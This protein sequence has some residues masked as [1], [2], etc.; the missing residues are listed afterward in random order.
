MERLLQFLPAS[1]VAIAVVSALA[2]AQPNSGGRTLLQ[3]GNQSVSAP[4]QSP[5]SNTQIHDLLMRVGSNQHRDD[6]TLDS[7]ERVEHVVEREDGPDSP[8]TNDK[9]YRVVPTG[10]GNLRLLIRENGKPVSPDVYQRQLRDWERALEIAIHPDDPREVAVAAKQQ[11]RLK[12]RAKLIDSVA[13]AFV[14]SWQGREVRDGR[15]LEKLRFEPNPNYQPHGDSTDWL[16]HARATVWIDAQSAQIARV[17]ADIIRDISIG[18]GILGKVYHGT[19]FVM[20]Q[21]Q[22]AS[23]IWEP[24]HYEYDISGRKFLFSFELHEVT[25]L[26]RYQFI[27]APDKALVVARNNL[28]RCCSFP[29]DP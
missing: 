27:G 4:D 8:V 17:E 23:D 28:A 26:S 22:A 2:L 1:L 19:H 29:A 14:V 13:G 12:D 21:A 15:V 9:T 10:S 18:G 16:V 24:T 25:T 20:D 5:L 6:A 11:R 7:F 3:A